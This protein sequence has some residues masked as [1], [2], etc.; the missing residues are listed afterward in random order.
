MPQAT[1]DETQIKALFKEA[2]LEVLDERKDLLRELIEEI[3][4]DLG[5]VRAIGEGETT[6]PVSREE[7]FHA[8]EGGS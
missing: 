4:E 6:E 5:M 3:I 2:L 7:V 8:L 1:L